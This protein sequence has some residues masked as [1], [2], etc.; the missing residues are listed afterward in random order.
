MQSRVEDD[1]T[2]HFNV[3]D[4]DHPKIGIDPFSG[5]RGY[6]VG[7]RSLTWRR[8]GYRLSDLGFEANQKEGI[9]VDWPIRYK[10]IAPWYSYVEKYVGISGRKEGIQHL[11]DGEFLK[12]IEFNCIE[13]HFS[14]RIEELYD[15][16]LV[17]AGRSAN[18]TE[19]IGKRGPCQFRNLCSRGCPFSGYFSSNSATLPDAFATGN[20]TLRPFSIVAKVLYDKDQKKAIGVRVIDSETKES[21]DYY[22][23]VIF[24]NASTIAT[25]AILLQSKSEVFP[26]GLGNGS[27][28]VGHNLM[29]H[30]VMAGAEGESNE[31]LDK[32]YYGRNPGCIYIPR[33]RNLDSKTSAKDFRRGYAFQGYGERMAWNDKYAVADGFGKE[34]K[35]ELTKP[36]NW[37][38]WIGAWGETLPYFNNRVE[39]EGDKQDQWGLPILNI[40]FKYG[41]NER[42]M[43]KDIKESA[44]EMLDKTG[45]TNIVPF[46]YERPPG[47][48]VHEMG[49]ARMGRD[50]KTSVLNAFNQMHEVK[51]VFITDGSCMT[52]SACQN[53][54]L[55]YMALTARACSYAV[56]EMKNGNL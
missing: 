35:E 6:Q 40:H 19:K 13:E 20:L 31:Y 11:P 56:Q 43:R 42:N 37:R 27:G 32:Y 51:N 38:L 53:P 33:F 8:Q 52:S 54:S 26:D 49:T 55:T 22:A 46:N 15:D 36:G 23:R 21:F 25:A 4:A 14:K 41:E 24:L 50:P 2:E 5:I 39:L 3:K 9:A 17:T 7:G 16:R 1:Y 10:D 12:P 30:F 18:L 29:D 44:V 34:F 28:Q 45:F 48:A 47:S